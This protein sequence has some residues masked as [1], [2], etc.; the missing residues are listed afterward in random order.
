MADAGW[1]PDP[2]DPNAEQ[3]WD[4]QM[5]TG[6]LRGAGS[7]GQ[8]EDTSAQS[9]AQETRINPVFAAAPEPPAPQPQPWQDQGAPA[10]PQQPYGA[11]P[12]YGTAG[13]GATQ[14]SGQGYGA[15][16]GSA[17][18]YGA[19]YGAAQGYSQ[20]GQPGPQGG[21]PGGAQPWAGTPAPSGKKRRNLFIAAGVVVV[22]VAAG[23]ITWLVLPGDDAPSITYQGKAINAADTVLTTAESSVSKTVA[24]RHGVKS[25]DTR[26]YFVQADKPADG[27]K[28]SDVD[29]SLS[30]GPVLFVDGDAAQEYL[31][32]RL[33]ADTSGS[34]ANLTPQ[35]SLDGVDPSSVRPGYTLVR[36]DGKTRPTGNGGLK[37]PLPPATT[38][39]SIIATSLG[40]TAA[41]ATLT[42]A[43]MVGRT[44]KVTV[45]AAG[46]ITRYGSGT[47]ARSA[48]S[49]QKLLAFRT[50]YDVGD[51]SSGTGAQVKLLVDGVA[52]DV[53]TPGTDE[54]VVAAVPASSSAS[55]QLIDS[56]DTQSLA[57]P[58]GTPASSNI[59]VLTR[60]H[61]TQLLG[62][63]FNVVVDGTKAGKKLGSATYRTTATLARLDYWPPA[64][65]SAKAS[66]PTRALLSVRV[67]FTD[68]KAKGGPF[69]Y[70][71]PYL[72]LRLPDGT[73]VAARNV[74]PKGKIANVF[75]VPATFTTGVL[76]ISGSEKDST[77]VTVKVRTAMNIPISIAAG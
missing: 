72:H 32:V 41:P 38:K 46:Y 43:V 1:Y 68:S 35:S 49:G 66:S 27:A 57:L 74:A 60:T 13:Y 65:T 53:P 18:G 19:G 9:G 62:R 7:A 52:K 54:Y 76:T 22:L 47:D 50:T 56:G 15:A 20:G 10:Q 63:T 3:Y 5:W 33:T 51:I 29:S 69:G 34:K 17:P 71:P 37:V 77:G 30:C 64:N 31:P 45:S 58:A 16:Q 70:D 28:K 26:C 25:S 42:T 73:V 4:G 14:G 23:L 36:P 8:Q 75:D 6:Q 67:N 12:G 40:S 55:L 39:D 61:R 24:S 59:A 11:A 48:P 2:Q 44:R 21:Q